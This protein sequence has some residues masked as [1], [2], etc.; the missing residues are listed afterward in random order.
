MPNE[1]R[2]SG[3]QE[4]QNKLANMP[5]I[6]T[7]QIDGEV[8]DAAR[9]WEELAVN[10][11]PV[12]VGF[13]KGLISKKRNAPMDWEVI[14]GAEYSPYME[15]GT[16]GRARVPSTIAAY[17][18]QFRGKGLPGA[19][20]FIYEWMRRKGIPKERWYITFRSI[21]QKGV[22]PHP[23]FFIQAPLVEQQLFSRI[24]KIINT[25]H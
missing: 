23:Y 13:L 2:L 16:K 12:D 21:M 19:K 15:W 14:S 11:A 22:H 20:A 17:A 10:A 1:I 6:M 4:F 3:F 8:E 5:R 7:D 18:A 24:R 9:L 25:E